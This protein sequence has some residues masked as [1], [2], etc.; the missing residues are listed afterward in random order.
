VRVAIVGAG[1]AGLAAAWRLLRARF[2]D[3]VVLELEGAAGGTARSG[4]SSVTA[5]PWGAHYIPA[6]TASNR[7]LCAMLGEMALFEGRDE[8]GDPVVAE[9]HRCRDPEER[10]FYRGRWYEGLYLRVG[11]SAA[12]LA[13][14]ARF[15]R[16]VEHWAAWRD[17][18]GR[19][20]FA[21]PIANG[22]D[23]AEVT[24]LDRLTMTEWLDA[25]GYQSARLRWWI[26]YAC[27]DDYG[28]RAS[29]TSAWAGLFYFASRLYGPGAESR[30]LVTWPQGNGRLIEHL[31]AGLRGRLRLNAAVAHIEPRAGRGAVVT[32]LDGSGGGVR[33]VDAEHVIFAGPQFVAQRV[34]RGLDRPAV[35]AFEHG[36][37]MVANLHL[38]A[39]PEER[40]YPLCWDNVLYESP[41]LGYVVATHQSGI[42][43]G[44]TV[45]TYYYPFCDS[46]GRAHLYSADW[47]ELAD[48]AL[49]DLSRAHPDLRGM[50]RRL[51][52]MRWGHAMIRPRPGFI[53]G[54]ARRAA[55]Q[56]FRDVWFANTDLSG[57]ALFEEAFYH[58]VR[59]AEGV[60]ARYSARGESLL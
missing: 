59:A 38:S 43:R 46:D 25:H 55:A 45:L 30:P 60:L 54:A 22:S 24:A 12:D 1:A 3:F 2:D 58:G 4:C 49:T 31:A 7:A 41:S 14:H 20:A 23:D 42:D 16:E 19:R 29:D 10:V 35:H 17:A 15:L 50:T 37:W 57:V 52:V 13:E 11:A 34:V 40:G 39:R 33:A 8:H 47:N 53:W 21:I 48:V 56:P 26:D 28:M 6:P 27:R 32:V 5:Y 9:V 51:D 18:R 44:A 36:A